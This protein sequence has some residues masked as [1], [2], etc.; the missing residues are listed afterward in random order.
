MK[1][2]TGIVLLPGGRKGPPKFSKENDML[3][4]ILIAGAGIAIAASPAQAQ[5]SAVSPGR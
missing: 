1:L 5:F 3:K 2:R 4:S